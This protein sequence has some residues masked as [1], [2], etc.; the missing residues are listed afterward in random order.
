MAVVSREVVLTRYWH[1]A[2]RFCRPHVRPALLLLV[3]LAASVA[4]L[5]LPINYKALGVYGYLGVFLVTLLGT[6]AMV[7]PVPYLGFVA[8][9]GRELD[10]L[11]VAVV[12]GAAA[13]LGE[14]TGYLV[15][16][17]G[18]S[19]IGRNRWY[20]FL[21]GKIRRFGGPIVLLGAAVPNP[22][23][24]AIGVVAGAT[25]MPLGLFLVSCFLGRTVRLY[26]VALLGTTL[27]PAG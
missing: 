11:W 4:L 13:A 25:R 17:T 3:V 5:F 9:A 14:L 22:L 16:Y 2:V 6:G 20:G 7:L 18:R 23:F 21:E 1:P 27:P 10:P 19:L 15:G 8:M 24:D 26:L 12:A